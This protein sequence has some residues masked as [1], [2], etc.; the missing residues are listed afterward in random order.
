[1]FL[2]IYWF[3]HLLITCELDSI[4]SGDVNKSKTYEQFEVQTI[5][6]I[7]RKIA[8]HVHYTLLTH[9]IHDYCL[10][11]KEKML[12]QQ[13]KVRIGHASSSCKPISNIKMWENVIQ[14]NRRFK[15]CQILLFTNPLASSVYSNKNHI[16]NV[17]V[18][19][20]SEIEIQFKCHIRRWLRV[21]WLKQRSGSTEFH[22]SV[23]HVAMTPDMQGRC[24]TTL[25]QKSKFPSDTFWYNSRNI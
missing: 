16:D 5:F 22:S 20:I 4:I 2:F 10:K 19:I 17:S 13:T 23:M 12:K 11:Q 6:S 7:I 14:I 24:P 15:Y 21:I 1:M 25:N 9:S 3:I 18:H 8:I